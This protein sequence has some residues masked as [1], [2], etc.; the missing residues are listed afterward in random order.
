LR[1]LTQLK[2]TRIVGNVEIERNKT[3]EYREIKEKHL[4]RQIKKQK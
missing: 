2:Q 1:Q 4:R 3:G